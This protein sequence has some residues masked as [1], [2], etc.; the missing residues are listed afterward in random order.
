MR[1]NRD[2]KARLRSVNR[3]ATQPLGP[4]SFGNVLDTAFSL[5]RRSFS[6]V[7]LAMAIANVPVL[8]IE[9]IMLQQSQTVLSGAVPSASAIANL[10][11]N[12]NGLGIVADLLSLLGVAAVLVVL[13]LVYRGEAAT[14]G[15][16][17]S[18]AA[19]RYL[20]FLLVSIVVGVTGVVG[21]ILLIIP[22][23]ILLTY[24]SQT[25]FLTVLDGAGFGAL[26][27]SW[28]L[29]SG[30]FWRVLGI[31]VVAFLI[32]YVVV[33]FIDGLTGAIVVAAAGLSPSPTTAAAAIAVVA[34]I[35]QTLIGAFP[36]AALYV[37]HM[38]LRVRKE[39]LD[40]AGT[41]MIGS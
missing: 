25:M 29:V 27:R 32:Y 1:A 4:K 26:G 41:G 5:Y 6:T 7:V 34:L 15:K 40:L 38:D 33:I 28:R 23:V 13:D 2:P 18:Q 3:L 24:F 10:A 21:L 30:H 11:K 39:G 31:A 8:I 16:A 12:F 36:L 9:V 14:I 17:Y 20:M 22:G 37:Q 19:K 35:V